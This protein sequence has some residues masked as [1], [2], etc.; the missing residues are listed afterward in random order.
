[1]T[2]AEVHDHLDERT[3]V[4][5]AMLAKRARLRRSRLLRPAQARPRSK[6]HHGQ[7]TDSGSRTPLDEAATTVAGKFRLRGVR[8]PR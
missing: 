3:G 7:L 5:A 1:M 4:L 8:V 6:R 2:T